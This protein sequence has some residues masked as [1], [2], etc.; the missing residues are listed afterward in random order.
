MG[1]TRTASANMI[2]IVPD[3]KPTVCQTNLRFELIMSC[4][5]ELHWVRT[6][7]IE[8]GEIS[9]KISIQRQV[10]SPCHM[11]IRLQEKQLPYLRGSILS[12]TMSLCLPILL[13]L[14]REYNGIE[15][16]ANRRFF[17]NLAIS[18]SFVYSRITGNIPN[19]PDN[20]APFTS[21][22][23]NPNDLINFYWRRLS[24]IQRLHGKWQGFTTSLGGSIPVGSFGMKAAIRGRQW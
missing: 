15:V 4:R 1:N 3:I 10:T 16:I 19:S 17:G 20:V 2:S 8:S 5:A 13:G 11:S 7:F 18:G 23:D 9:W 24:M 22:L 14:F 12:E 21:F 6:T